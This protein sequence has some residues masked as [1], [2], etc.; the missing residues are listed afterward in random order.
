M[1][2]LALALLAESHLTLNTKAKEETRSLEPGLPNYDIRQDNSD[3]SANTLTRYRQTLNKTASSIADVRDSFVAGEEALRQKVPS[4]K[5]E[6]NE[7]IRIPEVIGTDVQQGPDFLI[8]ASAVERPEILRNFVKENS[9]LL[10]VSDAQASQLEIKAD[11]KNP[12]D[13]I[14]FVHLEQRI[15]GVPVFR[16]E[17]KAAFTNN[18]EVIRVIN[19]L[20]PGLDYAGVSQDFRSPTDAVRAAF[21]NAT[22]AIEMEDTQRNDAESNDL[23]SVFGSGDSATTAEKIYFPTEPGVAVP[24]WR[25]IIWEPV[26]VYMVIVDAE[27]GT[28]L[29]RK[30]ATEEQTQKATYNVYNNP[31]GMINTARNPAPKSPG[32]VNPNL[33]TQGS[34]G[35]RSNVSRIGNEAPYTFNNLGWITDGNNTTDGNAV[36]AGVDRVA[37]D[38]VDAAI[39]GS[40]NRQFTSSWNPPAGNSGQGD[41]PLFPQSQRGAVIQMFYVMNLYH[42]ELYRFGFTESAGNYQ[43]DNFGRG[44]TGGDRIRAEGQD[45]SGTNNANFSTVPDGTRGRMQMYLWDGPT[46]DRDGTADA[47]IIIHEA[48]HGTSQRLIGNASG[49]TTNMSKGLGEGW[50]DFYAHA[51]L[52]H[53][54]DPINGVYS[55]GG[56]SLHSVEPGF[57]ANYYYGIR[58]FPKAVISFTGPNGRPH[59]PLSF[60]HLNANCNTEI[61]TPQAIGTISAYPRGPVGSQINCSQVH[62][63]GEIWSSALWEVRAKFVSRLGWQNGNRKILQFVTTAMKITP[64]NPTFLQARDA[65]LTI[66]KFNGTL[67]DVADIWEGFALRGMGVNAS[68]QNIGSTGFNDIVVTENF[69]VPQLTVTVAHASTSFTATEGGPNPSNGSLTISSTAAVGIDTTMTNN[70]DWLNVVQSQQIPSATLVV[71]SSGLAAGTY[72]DTIRV[73][74]PDAVNSPLFVPV[75]LTVKPSPIVV[76]PTALNFSTILGGTTFASKQLSVTNASTSTV[77]YGTTDNASWLSVG[78]ISGNVPAGGTAVTTVSVNSSG[79]GLGTYDGK[80]TILNGG[81]TKQVPVT[82]TVKPNPP[83]ISVNPDSL[84]ISANEGGRNPADIPLRITNSGGG[85]LKWT[86]SDDAGW[87][88]V[89]PKTGS[90]SAGKLGNAIVSINI[91]GLAVGTHNGTISITAPGAIPVNLSVELTILS[92]TQ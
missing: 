38:G 5:V 48:T 33:G 69:Q 53:P 90:V 71:N 37:P 51:M 68:I 91:A 22:R 40:P 30:N 56:Y 87:L 76:N 27:T 28:M 66:A 41:D 70:A 58:R 44:G 50:S 52:S 3:E 75:T 18:G 11:Y 29:W 34:I 78:A 65:I 39:V 85:T 84:I 16:G 47:E 89:S 21:S 36:Q 12:E 2:S 88:S 20:A 83:V 9:S 24:A 31:F 10:G 55:M 14:S 7:D 46:P 64:L 19:N 61:G 63:A 23:K 35:I 25:V 92:P 80:V 57:T 81:I 59:N 86:V 8:G 1:L 49:L 4:L 67:S 79:L 77:T 73:D 26:N 74:V 82:L 45:S 60:R 32:P 54:V 42:D 15:N 13:E 17:I 72:T 43:N 6:Y 62:N